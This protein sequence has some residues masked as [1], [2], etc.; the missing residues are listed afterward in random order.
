MRLFAF[1]DILGMLIAAL[2]GSYIFAKDSYSRIN[3]IFFI[4][5]LLVI[6]TSLCEYF[7][8]TAPDIAWATFWQKISILWPFF[9]AI[10]LQFVMALTNSRMDKNKIANYLLWAPAF[11]I[12]GLHVFTDLLYSG[13]AQSWFGW[14]FIPSDNILSFFITLYFAVCGITSWVIVIKHYFIQT[15]KNKR[16]QLL[17]VFSGVAI[18][19]VSG[20]LSKAVLPQLGYDIP[21]INSFMFVVSSFFLAVGI[22]KYKSF[23]IEP[24]DA[25]KRIFAATPDYFIIFNQDE[26]ILLTSDSFLNVSGFNEEEMLGKKIDFFFRM[27]NAPAGKALL[28]NINLEMELYAKTNGNEEIPISATSSVMQNNLGTEKAYL[29]LGRDL[30]ERKRLEK[31]LVDMQKSLEERVEIRTAELAKANQVLEFENNERKKFENALRNSE[32]RIKDLFENAP[33]GIYRTTPGG[34]ILLA[35]PAIVKMLG[36]DSFEEL[37]KRNLEEEGYS[38]HDYSREE[39]KRNIEG[40]GEIIGLQAKWVKKNG[41]EIIVRENAKCIYDDLGKVLYYDG[42]VEDIT[43]HIMVIAAFHTVIANQF[44]L[45]SDRVIVRRDYSAFAGHY[46]FSRI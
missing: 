10:F 43:D 16:N 9:P 33:I 17:L 19:V 30:R 2:I 8:I 23:L 15:N 41:K 18:P 12:A 37:T 32:S 13:L 45:F 4:N 20:V 22:S 28:S 3:K 11:I 25:I 26:E 31:E 35:N 44:A 6:Y 34:K 7:F 39:F 46:I 14:R 36:Y 24:V 21:P 42:T 38:E 1:I 5:T 27:N 40:K 29:L